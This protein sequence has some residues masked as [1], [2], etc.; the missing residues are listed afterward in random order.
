MPISTNINSPDA[1]YALMNTIDST[2][3][4]QTYIQTANI[5]MTNYRPGGSLVPSQSIAAGFNNFS[6]TYDGQGYT[7]TIAGVVTGYTG[8]FDS[9]TRPT[10]PAVGGIIRNVNVIYSNLISQSSITVWGGLVGSATVSSISNCSVRVNNSISVGLTDASYFGLI[11]GF[12]GQESTLTNSTVTINGDITITGANGSEIGLLCGLS[13]DSNITNCSIIGTSGT[14]GISL[15]A[16]G[17]TTGDNS[18][19]GL[20]CG[21]CGVGITTL[22]PQR[23]SNITVSLNNTGNIILDIGGGSGS[24]NK[25]AICGTIIGVASDIT[26][27]ENCTININNNQTLVGAFN[28]FFG[29]VIDNVQITACQFNYTT[30]TNNTSR[31]LTISP[32]PAVAAVIYTNSFTNV[33]SLASGGNYYIPN[34]NAIIAL[35]LQPITLVKTTAGIIINNALQQTNTTFVGYT[36]QYT[37][38]IIVKGVGSMYFG[39]NYSAVPNIIDT[40]EECICQ[41]NSCSTNPQTGVT[42]DSRITNINEDKTIRINVDREFARHSV[43]YPK[44][45]SYSDYMKYLQA[46]LKY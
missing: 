24:I 39:F 9:V 23:L 8:L 10:P 33:Y 43:V 34:D 37:Y 22:T 21:Y 13:E 41:V 16:N 28:D 6:G 25:G 29:Q 1:L 46:G 7:I 44:F 31:S 42:A 40:P 32:T 14:Y 11:C 20:I 3:L 17:S 12:M 4:G 19:I 30:T 45:K 26:V 15:K 27:I 5:D 35:G 36:S 2:D 18:D 38:N